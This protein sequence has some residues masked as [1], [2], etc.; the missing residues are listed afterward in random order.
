[1][2]KDW[3]KIEQRLHRLSKDWAK[4]EIGQ[5]LG[6][7]WAKIGQRLGKVSERLGKDLSDH[8]VVSASLKSFSLLISGRKLG[9]YRA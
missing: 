3:A 2:D 4:T 8:L 6:K 5:R 7:D 9:P 1:M